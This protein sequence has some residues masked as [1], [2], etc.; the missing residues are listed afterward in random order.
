MLSLDDRFHC[1]QRFLIHKNRPDTLIFTAT[2]PGS[3]LAVVGNQ[4][5]GEYI[6]L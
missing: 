3:E 2:E 5:I 4:D 6:Y 1:I